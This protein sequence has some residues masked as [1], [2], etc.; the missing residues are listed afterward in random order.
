MMAARCQRTS[1]SAT[2]EMKTLLLDDEPFELQLLEHQLRRLG[3]DEVVACRSARAALDLLPGADSGFELIFCDLQM[4]DIDGVELIRHLREL[5]Y[6]GG[7]ILVSGEDE[8]I[9]L[10]VEQL[11]RS[12]GLNVLG[13]LRKPIVPADLAEVLLRHNARR[14]A[15]ADAAAACDY[16]P[17]R[18]AAAIFNG[19]LVNHYQPKVDLLDGTLAGVETLV[20]WQ[21]PHD[22]LVFPDRFVEVAERS[23]RIDDL[24][25]VVMAEAVRQAWQWRETGLDIKVAVN[26]SMRSLAS[27]S[28]ADLVLAELERAHMPPSALVIEVTETALM[29]DPRAPL[30]ILNRLRLKGIGLSIDDFGTGNASLAKLRDIP[31][32]ELKIDRGFVHGAAANTLLRA[33]T[34]TSLGMAKRLGMTSVAEGVEDRSDWDFLSAIGCD[35]AQG[36]FIARPM[37]PEDFPEWAADWQERRPGLIA[38]P[39]GMAV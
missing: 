17:E 5:N 33:I 24:T 23:G 34:E 9:L 3:F 27:L 21:H 12:R 15:A 8:R 35:Q 6:P 11:A 26:V 30:D 16:A 14:D 10:S 1:H 7:L 2:P 25:S 19:E 32:S 28:F 29:Q 39:A 4:P 20:R 22:G 36:Y 38:R 31:F 18:V 37:P 13:A